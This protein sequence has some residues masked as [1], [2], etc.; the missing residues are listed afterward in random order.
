MDLRCAP[1]RTKRPS[2]RLGL[3]AIG[4]AKEDGKTAAPV[5]VTCDAGQP[6]SQVVELRRL[7]RAHLFG[8]IGAGT[9]LSEN[10]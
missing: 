3:E 4:G 6:V 9:N 5:S 7:S 8:P 10:Q 2:L 1:G